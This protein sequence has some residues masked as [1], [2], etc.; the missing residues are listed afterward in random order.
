VGDGNY[1][2]GSEAFDVDDGE[3]EFNEPDFSGGLF[4]I[5]PRIPL[6]TGLDGFE[7]FSDS[8]FESFGKWVASLFAIKSH[9][10][11]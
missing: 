2:Y 10:I 4:R 3:G 1:P 8:R 5:Q 11:L 9:R 6:W 7:G